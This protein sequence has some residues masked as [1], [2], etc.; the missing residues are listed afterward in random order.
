M[1]SSRDQCSSVVK[2]LPAMQEVCVR[3]LGWEDSPGGGNGNTLQYSCLGNPM[4]GG[5]W[6]ATV[7]GITRSGLDLVT[8]QQQQQEIVLVVTAAL[9]VGQFGQV[10]GRGGFRGQLREAATDTWWIEARDGA[11]HSAGHRRALP[12]N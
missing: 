9:G 6:W 8:K 4:V 12:G 2:N 11:K 7:H 10:V 1:I 5:A 3:S